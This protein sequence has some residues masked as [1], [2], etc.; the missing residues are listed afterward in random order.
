VDRDDVVGGEERD[1]AM[2]EGGCCDGLL[3][4]QGLGVGKPGVVIDRGMQV[5]VADLP[6]AGA[7]P[8]G[9]AGGVGADAVHPPA[10]ADRDAPE[11]LDV[12][13]DHVADAVMLVADDLAQL[14]AGWR[15]EVAQPVES[16]ADEDAV[17]G[18]RRHRDAVQ[19]LELGSQS[20]GPILGLPSQRLHQVRDVLRGPGRARGRAGRMVEQA[21][22]AVC[23]PAGVPLGQAAAGYPSFRRDMRDRTPSVHA[24]T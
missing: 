12:N 5:G 20:C 16:S 2:P 9:A 18:G 14:V 24:L 17:H 19:T 13:V 10:A 7:K 8:F 4:L 22:L 1:G 6:R 21:V 15:I 3:V 11:L 23:P